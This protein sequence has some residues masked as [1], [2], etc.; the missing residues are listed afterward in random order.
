[1]TKS[2]NSGVSSLYT[3]E[4]CGSIFNT[5]KEKEEHIELK[6]SEGKSPSN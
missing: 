2:E 5:S 3:C 1:M 6:H 4:F